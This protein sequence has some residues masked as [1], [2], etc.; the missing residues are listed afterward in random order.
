VLLGV[1]AT[2]LVIGDDRPGRPDWPEPDPVAAGAPKDLER[3]YTQDLEWD[4]CEQAKCTSIKVPLEYEKPDGKTLSLR[5]HVL[6]SRGDGGRSLFFNPGGPGA[7][8]IPY[9]DFMASQFGRDVRS[10]FDLVFVDPRGVGESSPLDCLSDR[11]LDAAL[12]SDPTPDD[13]AEITAYRRNSADF[14]AG[15]RRKSGDLSAHVSTEEAARDFDIVRGLLGATTFDWFGAS[16]GSQLGATYASLFPTN[17][18][19]MVLDG[20]V[21]TSLTAP[22]LARGQSEGFGRAMRAYIKDCLRAKDCPLGP[23]VAT[24]EGKLSDLLQAADATPLRTGASRLLTEGLMEIGLSF[25]LYAESLWP[26]LT[27]ALKSAFK[28]DGSGLLRLSDLYTERLADGN[29]ASNLLEAFPAVNCLDFDDRGTP[30]DVEKALPHFERANPVFGRSDAWG[31][32][33]CADWP[34]RATHPQIDIDANGSKPI[35]VLG[36]T[37]DPATPYEW[38]EALAGQLRTGVLVTREGDGHTAYGSGNKCIDEV[39][40]DYLVEGKVPKDGTT[41]KE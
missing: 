27:G 31:M 4:D 34:I 26:Q 19:R 1:I 32:L 14:G 3:F 5:V 35:I 36:T 23:D 38:S 40:D 37:R 39:V 21:D 11:D 17:V 15:C 30:E 28:G 8:A 22:E 6:P 10:R 41:C 16:Y 7:A 12:A 33:G 9:A 29:Y 13:G 2:A 18:G 24:A 20:G 25:P